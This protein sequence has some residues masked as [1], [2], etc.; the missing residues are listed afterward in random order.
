L[1]RKLSIGFGR[2]GKIIDRMEALGFV[3]A[4]NG[5]KPRNVL[6]TKQQL[7]EMEMAQ[8]PRVSGNFG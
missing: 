3:S 2:A 7:M 8:D 5:T 1:Q 6:I 4:A